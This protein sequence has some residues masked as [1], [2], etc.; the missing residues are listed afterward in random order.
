MNLEKS[1]L[2]ILKTDLNSHRTK[3]PS[4]IPYPKSVLLK[5]CFPALH[6]LS[7]KSSC[8]HILQSLKPNMQILASPLLPAL[9]NL[10]VQKGMF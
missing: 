6:T 3:L 7:W 8:Y 4:L 9:N 10:T 1:K 5:N 2:I